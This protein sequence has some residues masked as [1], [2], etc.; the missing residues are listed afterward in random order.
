[1]NLI[2]RTASVLQRY[3]SL[4]GVHWCSLLSSQSLQVGFHS[5]TSFQQQANPWKSVCN[6]LNSQVWHGSVSWQQP[7]ALDW[8]HG[9]ISPSTILFQTCCRRRCH[10]FTRQR[11]TASILMMR[12]SSSRIRLCSIVSLNQLHGSIVMLLT[13][14]STSWH[15]VLR[16]LVRLSVLGRVVMS[17]HT[18]HGSLQVPLH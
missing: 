2:R 4:C 9:C 12:G 15:G 10:V 7:L 14:R 13:V 1:M 16:K 11:S 3:L 8:L 18:L 17:V 5:D 6:I